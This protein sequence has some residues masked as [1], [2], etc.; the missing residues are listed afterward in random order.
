DEF[1]GIVMDRDGFKMP[2]I[3]PELNHEEKMKKLKKIINE[4]WIKDRVNIPKERHKKY[5]EAIQFE[6]NIID[7]TETEDY[8]LLNYPI[9]KRGKELGGVLTR[10]GRGSAPSFYL[11]KL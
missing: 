4:E 9:I 6:M 2:S 7:K 8:F 1:E 11:N 5:I 10:T 3:Y